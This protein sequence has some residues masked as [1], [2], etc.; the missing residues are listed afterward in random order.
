MNWE[1]ITMWAPKAVVKLSLL[2]CLGGVCCSLVSAEELSRE[3]AARSRLKRN[4]TAVPKARQTFKKLKKKAILKYV[5]PPSS[6]RLYFDEGTDE[7]ELEKVTQMEIKQLYELFKTSKRPDIQLR[8]ASLY[9]EQSR[10]IESR[11]Y[12]KYTLNMEEYKRGL[13]GSL[14]SLDLSLVREYS[15]KAINLF[16][17]YLQKYPKSKRV[18]EVYFQLGYSYFQI[19]KSHIGKTYY[20]KLIR[21]HPKSPYLED[22]HFHLGEYYFDQTK[23]KSARIHYD[24][25]ARFQSKFYSF[26]L[27]KIAW[28][29]FNEGKVNLAMQFMTRVIRTAQ[30][31]R[32]VKGA[33]G[34]G[35]SSEALNDLSSFYI[36]SKKKASEAY[37]YF[38]SLIESE[39]EVLSVLRRVGFAYKDAGENSNMRYIF[40]LLIELDPYNAQAFDYKYQIVQ[41]YSYTGNRQ[42]FDKEFRLWIQSYGPDSVWAKRNRSRAELIK[43]SENLMEVT[44]RNYAFRMHHAFLKTRKNRDRRQAVLGYQLYLRAFPKS[45][46]DPDIRFHYGEILFD[47]NKLE[48]AAEQYHVVVQNYPKSKNHKAAALNRVLALEKTLPTEKAVQEMQK[49]NEKGKK[50]ALPKN[51]AGFNTAVKQYAQ[52]YPKEKNIS[53]MLYTTAKLHSEYRHYETAV[54]YWKRIVDKQASPKNPYFSRSIHSILDTY[55]LLKDFESLK[56]TARSFLQRSQIAALPV[57]KEILKI[58]RQ[59]LFKEAQDLAK[60]GRLAESAKMYEQFFRK[61]QGSPLAVSALYNSALNYNKVKNFSKSNRLYQTLMGSSHLS[62]YP[63]IQKQVMQDIADIYQKSGQYLKAA[64]AFKAYAQKYPKNVSA[65]WYN[66]A[67]I[68]DGLNFYQEAV[69]AYVK[70]YNQSKGRER[71]QIYFL[72]A[73][74][75]ERR[76]QKKSA[77]KHYNRYLQ[78]PDQNKLS[79]VLSAFRLAELHQS[80]GR[81]AEAVKWRKTTLRLYQKL[82]T[83]IAFAAQSQ[84]WMAE[85]VYK[86]FIGIRIPS[87]PQQQAQAVQ[88]KLKLLEQLK[89]E[90]K[91]VIRFNYGPE[92]VSSLNLMGLANHH[93]GQAIL[94][95]ALPKGLGREDRKKYREGLAQTAKP[96]K[97]S[98]REYFR[99]AVEKSENVKGY[100]PSLKTAQKLYQQFDNPKMSFGERFYSLYFSGAG[101]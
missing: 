94:K 58:L 36:Y 64:N 28:C 85:Q 38:D 9:V 15:Q 8:L 26:S 3:P 67:I 81:P 82:Q 25:A 27:Y 62:K 24:R 60:S 70:Y 39:Q 68:F 77:V 83:G 55:N 98:A 2:A 63:K 95:S 44:L 23:W 61:N 18:S 73:R 31:L 53:N 93:L 80:L 101:R 40:N 11:I 97:D 14:P 72:M 86:K 48:Q 52:F 17:I 19:N 6:N 49:Q 16:R 54:Q 21:R 10:L 56:K 13:R 34:L 22:A 89:D 57:G 74:M 84:F 100:V 42:V 91:K 92:V 4:R 7:A 12:E 79:Q 5:K 37:S 1:T 41:A 46:F 96:F 33:S 29:L 43:K 88:R 32:R 87:N 65:Y 35:F 71:N 78:S 51:V 45:K 99:Q 66:A 90:V 59:A 50:I 20:E 75:S 76:K 30:N 47:S 69:N